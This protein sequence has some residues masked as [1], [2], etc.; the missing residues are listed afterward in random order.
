MCDG[1]IVQLGISSCCVDLKHN[2]HMGL[3]RA[4]LNTN[5]L[6]L[7][8]P[9]TATPLLKIGTQITCPSKVQDEYYQMVVNTNVGSCS[10]QQNFSA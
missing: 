2:L 3:Q 5:A 1:G 4:H 8:N 10:G 9:P 7:S 6:H